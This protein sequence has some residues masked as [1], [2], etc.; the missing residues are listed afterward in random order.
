MDPTNE[1]VRDY[2]ILPSIDMDTHHLRL[3][4]HNGISFDAYRSDSLD[5]LFGMAARTNIMEVPHDRAA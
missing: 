4:E 3:S 1:A 5:L 2:Y